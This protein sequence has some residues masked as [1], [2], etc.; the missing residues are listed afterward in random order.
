MARTGLGIP[1]ARRLPEQDDPMLCAAATGPART[2]CADFPA[3]PGHRLPSSPGMDV[4]V[5][6][7]LSWGLTG[8]RVPL[9]SNGGASTEKTAWGE[10]PPV[11]DAVAF[12]LDSTWYRG[13]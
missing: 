6:G 12:R 9:I 10:C 1:G 7:T 4:L 8:P 3:G 13:V 2:G 11:P 5:E